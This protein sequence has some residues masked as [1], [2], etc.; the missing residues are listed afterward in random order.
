MR[1]AEM[2]GRVRLAVILSSLSALGPMSI[3]M[4]LPAF[5]EVAESF[6][7]SES[8]VQLTLTACLAGLALGQLLAGPLSD[9][10]GRRRPLVIGLA[11]YVLASVG[12]ALAPTVEL[13]TVA[14]LLQGLAGAA[15]VTI[16]RAVARDLFD[17]AALAR[18]FSM[19]ILVSGL[20]P[21]VA[22]L[23]GSQ[24]IRVLPW[25]GVF[26]VLA[27]YGV[28]VLLAARF[29]LPETL[30]PADRDARG[31]R[32]TGAVMAQVLGDRRF[33][34]YALASG[35]L[36][37]A[38]F[39][40]ISGSPFV[41]QQIYR[42][43]PQQFGLAFGGNAL[44]ILI[45]SQLSRVLLRWFSPRR[46]LLAG[47]LL[48][49]AGGAGLLAAVLLRLGLPA[50]LAGLFAVVSSVGLVM[51]NA[52]AL[53]LTWLPPQRAGSAS[54]LLGVMQFLFGALAAP[55][56][57]VAGD[58]TAV[59]MASVI[60]GLTVAALLAYAL[61]TPRGPAPEPVPGGPAEPARPA[62]LTEPARPAEGT[63]GPG[64]AR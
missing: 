8:A 60:A 28:V 18:F 54:A 57:G 39:T 21:I 23:I 63:G 10:L 56:A 33:V 11:L 19:L 41:L 42:L 25:P 48:G 37:A 4:Y 12:C 6:G 59:P 17:G 22:P 46:L 40:Y 38:M 24:L 26:V 36:F 52:T 61:L 15:G 9:L 34:G 13:L 30:A 47:L 3:D 1:R 45:L 64:A 20:A 32:Q 44:G 2:P 16:V 51:P 55:L 29:G 49:L 35:L 43:S 58:A 7:S 14:R 53:A 27:G 50:V 62:E 31:F 5:P